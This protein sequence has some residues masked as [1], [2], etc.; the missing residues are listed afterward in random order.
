MIGIQTPVAPTVGDKVL[1][2]CSALKLPPPKDHRL[3]SAIHDL[4][5][6]THAVTVTFIHSDR[7]GQRCN[8]HI[9]YSALRHFIRVVNIKCFG[10][11]QFDKGRRV[12]V[13]AALG[14]GSSAD[15]PHYH[16]AIAAPAGMTFAEFEKLILVAIR[17]TRWLNQQFDVKPYRSEGWIKYLLDHQE[18][19]FLDLPLPAHPK[20]G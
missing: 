9:M 1:G 5:K 7:Y 16:M 10:R 6:W 4:A 12:S 20:I 8:E 13:V 11:K 14:M 19:L 2:V 18:D 15:H 17:K 3:Q